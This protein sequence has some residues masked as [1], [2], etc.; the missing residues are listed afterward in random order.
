MSCTINFVHYEIGT[1]C[2]MNCIINSFKFKDLSSDQRNPYFYQTNDINICR[3]YDANQF[4]YNQVYTLIIATYLSQ[5][6]TR[7]INLNQ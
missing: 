7:E 4:P 2:N 3:H 5:Y 1:K 6:G